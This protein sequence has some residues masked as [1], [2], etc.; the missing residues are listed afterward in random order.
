MLKST[1]DLP[2][3]DLADYYDL[4]MNLSEVMIDENVTE[5]ITPSSLDP[6]NFQLPS[7]IPINLLQSLVGFLAIVALIMICGVMTAG[8]GCH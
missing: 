4:A 6:Y 5:F 2:F 3:G 1:H 7:D 8:H